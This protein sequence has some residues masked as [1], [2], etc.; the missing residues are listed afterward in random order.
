VVTPLGTS[1]K[2]LIDTVPGGGNLGRNTFRGP[3]YESWNVSFAKTFK[4]TERLQITLRSDWTDFFNH[5]NFGPPVSSMNAPN[6]G[7]NTSDP[8]TRSAF[9]GAKV[10]F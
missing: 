1:G 2:P 4:V 5:R 6:F 7:A 8:G 3:A 9:L 10:S